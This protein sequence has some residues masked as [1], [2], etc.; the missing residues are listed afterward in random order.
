MP[1]PGKGWHSEESGAG[2][3]ET[4]SAPL[5]P[6]TASCTTPGLSRLAMV[7]GSGTTPRGHQ[8][9]YAPSV[10][11]WRHKDRARAARLYTWP[12]LVCSATC[13]G[14]FRHLSV[15]GVRISPLSRRLSAVAERFV[16]RRVKERVNLG[17]SRSPTRVASA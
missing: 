17:T 3:R 15:Q 11:S 2:Q 4:N 9:E 7:S 1:E 6:S 8:H 5:L 13:A 16:I 12:A 10:D 14:V